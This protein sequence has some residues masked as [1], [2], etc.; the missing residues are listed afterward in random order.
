MLLGIVQISIENNWLYFIFLLIT[1][2]LLFYIGVRSKTDRDF[3]REPLIIYLPSILALLAIWFTG[4]SSSLLFPELLLIPVIIVSVNLPRRIAMS[5]ASLNM[6]IIWL[7]AFVE[8]SYF[9]NTSSTV[10]L[11]IYT[12]LILAIPQIFGYLIRHRIHT[13]R[14][15]FKEFSAMEEKKLNK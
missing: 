12:I 13:Y 6:L 14:L 7:F 8:P 10:Y 3:M 15:V 9:P 11:F 2:M 4:G 1:G 5:V